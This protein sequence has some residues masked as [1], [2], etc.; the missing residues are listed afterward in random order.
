MWIQ[1]LTPWGSPAEHENMM[2]T[3]S[4]GKDMG[5]SH[6]GGSHGDD[7]SPFGFSMTD[8]DATSPPTT[9]P[10]PQIAPPTHPQ[11]ELNSPLRTGPDF[12]IMSTNPRKEPQT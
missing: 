4:R 9:P 6:I 8:G 1:G 10:P 7:T 3:R 2:R 12:G 11:R 5:P